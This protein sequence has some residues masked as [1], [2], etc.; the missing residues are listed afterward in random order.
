MELDGS[1]TSRT[2]P[3]VDAIRLERLLTPSR[4][5]WLNPSM[6]L[7]NTKPG[8]LRAAGS[9]AK[10][11]PRYIYC[12]LISGRARG[13][14]NLWLIETETGARIIYSRLILRVDGRM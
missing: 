5:Q 14:I 7:H 1:I 6:A 3:C 4:N 12:R 11:G 9:T 2:C 8:P 13:C 10:P